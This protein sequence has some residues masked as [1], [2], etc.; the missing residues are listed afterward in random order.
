VVGILFLAPL[1]CNERN[2]A[3]KPKT[4][5]LLD[6]S[7]SRIDLGEVAPGG[8]KRATFS[9][10]KTNSRNQIIDLVR[11]DSSCPCLAVDVP[12]RIAPGEQVV[13]CAKLDLR[14]DPDFTGEVAIEIQGWTTAG[15]QAFLVVVDVRV[16]RKSER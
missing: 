4:H 8:Q 3:Q 15:E 7:P 10:T 1:G 5:L 12:P 14:G 16:L 2:A 6:A 9:L 11:I 13:S